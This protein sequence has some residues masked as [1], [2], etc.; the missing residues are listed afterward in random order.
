MDFVRLFYSACGLR[1]SINLQANVDVVNVATVTIIY[2]GTAQQQT[3]LIAIVNTA[4]KNTSTYLMCLYNLHNYY[5]IGIALN[6][7]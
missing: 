7:A 6:I 3:M 4:K 2:Y 1:F 5:I